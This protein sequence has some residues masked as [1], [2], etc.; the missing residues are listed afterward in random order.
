M[1][2]V[3]ILVDLICYEF[4][5]SE[6]DECEFFKDLQFK[7][8]CQRQIFEKF[9]K[10]YWFTIRVF[11][12]NLLRGSQRRNIFNSG[13][14][15]NKPSDYLIDYGNCSYNHPTLIYI[16]LEVFGSRWTFP[17][18]LTFLSSTIPLLVNLTKANF[19]KFFKFVVHSSKH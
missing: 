18:I 4:W 16:V 8:N 6:L 12:R 1:V 2:Y 14:T 15:S 9:F 19:K 17:V 13:L 7:V 11:A 3:Y 10:A 5:W